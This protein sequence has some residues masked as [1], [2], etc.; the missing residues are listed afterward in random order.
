MVYLF[1]GEDCPAKDLQLQKLKVESVKNGLEQFNLDVLY[2]RELTLKALQEKLTYLPF[3]DSKRMLVIRQ[4]EDLKKEIKDFLIHYSL[5]PRK[6]TVLVLDFGLL[7][8]KDE[9]L[10]RLRKNSKVI[11]FKETVKPDTFVLSR[12]IES[13][14]LDT[15]LKLLDQLLKDGEKPERILGGLRYAWERGIANPV[16]TK[17]RLKLLLGCDIDIKT[18]RLKPSFALEKLVVGLCA[19][20]K[21]AH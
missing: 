1:I 6:D 20:G 2:S 4:A 8:R 17:R 12:S 14:R 21:P 9:F 3:K 15:A 19:A 11:L 5:E 18:G 7:Q 10:N 13:R 16:E